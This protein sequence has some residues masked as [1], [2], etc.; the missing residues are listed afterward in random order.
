MAKPSILYV[1]PP[2][3]GTAAPFA[4][5]RLCRH[6]DV[7]ALV[8]A[9]KPPAADPFIHERCASARWLRMDAPMPVSIV[10]AARAVRADAI[11]A[12]S[13]TAIVAVARACEE[14]GLRGPGPNVLTSRD[15]V[16]MRQC[17]Q[18]AGLPI[19]PFLPVSSLDDLRAADRSLARPF[20]LKPSWLAGSLA[21]LVIDEDTDLVAAWSRA[22][23]AHQQVDRA[24]VRDF[25]AE[26][27]GP[28]FI[29]EELIQATT[30]SWYDVDG[31]GDYVSVEG[32]VAR[33]RY[34][35]VSITARMPTVPLFVERGFHVPTVLSEDRQRRIEAL[36]R[37]AVDALGLEDCGTHTEIKLQADGGLCLLES[38]AR[39]GGSMILRL[40]EEIGRAHV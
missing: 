30:D 9:E 6:G 12:F 11:V 17:W 20:L 15:K 37:A 25:L 40:V 10:E 36:A 32:V 16:A 31:F 28:R 21:Q 22:V 13:E 26:G 8:V 1:I 19:P 39:F 33:G 23:A 35:P 34:H 27:Q 4:L 24:G 14:L 29:A 3:G 38:A 7:H 18:Q 2:V 5:P